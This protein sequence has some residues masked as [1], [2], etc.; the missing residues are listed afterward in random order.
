MLSPGGSTATVRT[1]PNEGVTILLG[2]PGLLSGFPHVELDAKGGEVVDIAVAERL[3]GE[4]TKE[5]IAEDARIVPTPVLGN[6][7]HV[8]RYI[9]RAGRQTFQRFE[10][11]A[12]KWM[13][14]TVRNAADGIGIVFAGRER[15]IATPAGTAGAFASDDPF[16]DQLWETGRNTVQLCMHDGWE[17]CPS[18]EQRQMARRRHG[19]TSSSPD[20]FR[21][22]QQRAYR[23]I[24]ARC[25]RE[26][27]S[28][29]T[30]ADVRAG[31]S[32]YQRLV[33]TRLDAAMDF[34]RR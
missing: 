17:D 21:S 24:S 29:R 26:P 2:F 19:R 8:A 15:T 25:R 5:G 16:L 28:G 3:P 22:C 13:Q 10:W 27:A 1:A 11:S 4:F 31:R 33:D 9:A 20:R 30:H 12:V 6:D 23:E 7:A 32:Q 34:D 14:I 18:R